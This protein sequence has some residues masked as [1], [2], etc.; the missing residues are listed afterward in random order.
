M[1]KTY[2]VALMLIIA[3]VIFGI[4]RYRNEQGMGEHA[5]Q[6]EYF[7][8]NGEVFHTFYHITYEDSVNYRQDIN[9]LFAQIDSSLS[10][11]NPKSII[12]R[13]NNNDTTVVANTF[14]RTVF[15]KGQYVSAQTHGCYD[16]TVAPLVNLWGFGF[17]ASDHV[18]PAGVDSCKQFVGYQTVSL[19]SAGHLHKQ[20]P[21][22]ILDA[23]SIAKGYACDVV[24]EFLQSKG[25]RNYMVEIGGEIALSGVNAKGSAW[26]VGIATPVPDSLQTDNGFQAYIT[27]MNGGLATSG[28]YRNFY[29]KEGKRIAHTIHP[30]TGYPVQSDILSA[31][32]I[33]PDCMTADAYATSF[34]VMGTKEAMAI[35]ENDTT[36][37]GYLICPSKAD[38]TQ[39]EIIYSTGFD[40]YIK[41]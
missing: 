20:D 27:N 33:A 37:A 1:K 24:A 3:V 14:F 32:V 29:E 2:Y 4:N 16:M 38:S 28:N 10:M 5:H 22:T 30:L 9:Q 25:V 35:L 41:K 26:T 34:M 11:F 12:S 36:I 40:K 21:R 13:M 23:S 15:E 7:K 39:L 18:T 19:D 6:L 31:T 8:L 17:K